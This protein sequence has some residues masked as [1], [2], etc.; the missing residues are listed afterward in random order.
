VG[1]A[2]V[3]VGARLHGYANWLFAKAGQLIKA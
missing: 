2:E 3:D 1:Q